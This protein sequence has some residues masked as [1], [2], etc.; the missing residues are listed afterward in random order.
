MIRNHSLTF[1]AGWKYTLFDFLL[2]DLE[3]GKNYGLLQ[4]FFEALL[5][6]DDDGFADA[7]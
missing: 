3:R 5:L 1:R 6:L 7:I 2:S 4:D